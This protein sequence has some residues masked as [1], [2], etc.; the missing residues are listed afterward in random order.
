[1]A[2]VGP[3]ACPITKLTVDILAEKLAQLTSEEMRSKAQQLAQDMALED[4]IQGGYE[5]F[6]G[7]LY[8]DNMLCD[9]NLILGH[10][11]SARYEL[12]GTGLAQ[13]G[14]KVSS[15]VAALLT[16]R[17]KL[18]NIQTL[19]HWIPTRSELNDRYWYSASMRRHSVTSYNLSGS[20]ETFFQ[21]CGASIYGLLY[22]AIAAPLQIYM[23]SDKWARRAGSIGCLWGV[24]VSGFYMV[25]YLLRA[26]LVFFDRLALGIANGC[27]G[28]DKDYV[29]DPSWKA[30]VRQTG[31]VEAEFDSILSTG[32][33]MARKKEL[34]RAL[35]FVV[36]A[37]IVFGKADPHHPT[38]HRHFLVVNLPKLMAALDTTD[39]RKKLH[40]NAAECGKV[41]AN[42]AKLPAVPSRAHR[43]AA[44]EKRRIERLR[45]F[46]V[47][48]PDSAVEGGNN[49]H[50]DD[51]GDVHPLNAG[52]ESESL[53]ARYVATMRR[54]FD[55]ISSSG[56][57]DRWQ[58]R[59]EATAVSFSRFLQCLQPVFA[60]KH[61]RT[62]IIFEDRLD[63]FDESCDIYVH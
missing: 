58:G 20:V 18:D 16:S 55:R 21:G 53:R 42:L 34:L 27:F 24:I 6:I 1:M 49:D 30:K 60:E 23:V 19:Q 54:L 15:E 22:Y 48:F 2:G 17:Y 12:I 28:Y 7:S 13:D 33:P 35:R 37:R 61:I 40:I 51:G 38:H 44:R 14:I 43:I 52:A 63:A 36:A 56:G 62:S 8:R 26:V 50:D 4:G 59:P 47:R 3:K 31:V 57:G 25:F 11:E 39:A 5:H 10:V 41:L 45:D 9:V 29:L 32:L 46:S